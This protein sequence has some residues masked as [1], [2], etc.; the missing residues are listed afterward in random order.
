MSTFQL[1]EPLPEDLEALDALR[2][3]AGAA[4][5]SIK[6]KV[7]NGDDLTSDELNDLRALASA[8]EKIDAAYE[9]ASA[10][11]EEKQAEISELLNATSARLKPQQKEEPP[12]AETSEDEPAPNPEAIAA[13]GKDAKPAKTGYSGLVKGDQKAATHIAKSDIG[14]E[15]TPNVPGYQPGKVGFSEVAAAMSKMQPGSAIRANRAPVNSQMRDL[16]SGRSATAD[17]SHAM[18]FA[19]INRG[20]T[21]KQ[22]VHRGED[23]VEAITAAVD[24]QAWKPKTYSEE[25]GAITAAG[26]WCAPSETLYDFCDV[27]EDS[28]LVSLPEVN[29]SRGGMRWPEE[30]DMTA[31]Y[32]SLPFFYTEAQLEAVPAPVKPCVEIPCPGFDEIRKNASGLCITVGLLQDKAWPEL[33]RKYLAEAVKAHMHDLH[34][35]TIAAMVA[36]SGAAVVIPAASTIG[37]AGSLLASLAWQAVDIRA[38]ERLGRTARIEGVAPWWALT[39]AQSDLAYQEGR[40]LKDVTEADVDRW[41][42]VRNISIQWVSDWQFRAAGQP[43]DPAAVPTTNPATV[44]VLLYP[45]GAFFRHVDNVIEV[46]NLYDKAQLQANT[47]TAL[48]TEDEFAV[49]KRC[50]ISRLVTV[51]VCVSGAVGGREFVTCNTSAAPGAA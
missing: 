41:L 4:F 37:A 3:E 9:A 6:A 30:P 48:F 42:S 29:I 44:D 47:K 22:Q 18:S 50:R 43:G 25:T 1:P 11:A 31:F 16:K 28:D 21:D 24:A 49:G 27:T 12:E 15:M 2:G 13:G 5:D 45:A 36:A 34:M 26:G 20:L 23:L 14:F 39:V 51:P 35:R 17:F 32:A 46:G 40:D 38:R 33:T 8:I 19:T 10:A 7:E